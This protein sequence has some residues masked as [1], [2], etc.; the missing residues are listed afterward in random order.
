MNDRDPNAAPNADAD[1]ARALDLWLSADFD[2]ALADLDV[3]APTDPD[4]PEIAARRTLLA[5]AAGRIGSVPPLDQLSRARL[6]GAA[7][8]ALDDTPFAV[9]APPESVDPLAAEAADLVPLHR[10]VRNVPRWLVPVGSAAAAIALVAGVAVSIGTGDRGGDNTVDS[11]AAELA[12]GTG[13]DLE[14]DAGQLPDYGDLSDPSTL[15]G[16]L[17]P[18]SEAGIAGVETAPLGDPPNTVGKATASTVAPL[19]D[20]ATDTSQAEAC[21][22]DLNPGGV[23]PT[24]VG[25]GT[26]EDRFVAVALAVEADA[27]LVF[28]FPPADCTIVDF[29]LLAND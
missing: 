28:V 5:E 2:D 4:A 12:E 25:T 23:V 18:S 1:H 11:A 10:S 29:Q 26:F 9:P 17:G 15:R 8:A 13:A 19:P 16:I 6:V 14:A 24:L 27:T 22:A 3:P 20:L 21:L 7:L